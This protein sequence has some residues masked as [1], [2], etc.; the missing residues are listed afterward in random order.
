ML[1]SPVPLVTGLPWAWPSLKRKASLLGDPGEVVST[2]GM[3]AVV[4]PLAKSSSPDSG[5]PSGGLVAA[6]K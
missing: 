1:G 6:G 2:F 3:E 4:K 5:N